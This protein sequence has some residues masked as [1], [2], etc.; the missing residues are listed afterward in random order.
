MAESQMNHHN[1]PFGIIC[2]IISWFSVTLTIT[3]QDIDVYMRIL[4]SLIAI[5]TGILAGINWYYSIKKNKKMAKK[6]IPF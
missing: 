5:V 4:C 2:T 1:S 6:D 3:L